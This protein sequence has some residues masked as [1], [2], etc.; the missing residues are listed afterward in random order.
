LPDGGPEDDMMMRGDSE[1]EFE[2]PERLGILDIEFCGKP[3]G[4]TPVYSAFPTGYTASTNA[5]DD[6]LYVGGGAINF[7]FQQAL[8]VPAENGYQRLHMSMLDV[9]WRSPGTLCEVV[10]PGPRDP[11]LSSPTLHNHE[12]QLQELGLTACFARVSGRGASVGDPLG[13]VFIDVFARRSCPSNP[14]NMAMLYV[15]GPKG[16]GADGGADASDGNSPISREEFLAAVEDM[17][18]NALA[19]VTEYN[20]STMDRSHLPCI[21]VVQWC[22]VSGGVYK[23]AE[24]TKLD[25]AS[26][27]LRGM[28]SC[29]EE[30]GRIPS[31]LPLMRFAYDEAAF[32]NA[33]EDN[34]S[35]TR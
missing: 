23:Q 34:M 5:G 14:L 11:R 35:E 3:E 31:S 20:M 21:E 10:L 12:A 7:A 26:A 13:A 29:A 27:T 18:H 2:P 15:V 24:C 1:Y 25:V 19:A 16:E 6:T 8:G 4:F 30:K 33:A 22:L 28:I 32:E 9:A 17:A